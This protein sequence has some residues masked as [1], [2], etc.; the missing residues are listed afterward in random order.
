MA[1]RKDTW[2]KRYGRLRMRGWSLLPHPNPK[3]PNL[4]FIYPPS[5]EHS[6]EAKEARRSYERLRAANAPTVEQGEFKVSKKAV[7]ALQRAAE[8]MGVNVKIT[9]V[10]SIPDLRCKHGNGPDCKKCK[11]MAKAARAGK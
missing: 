5:K 2:L 7:D 9:G 8:T 6:A 11:Q 1:E 10:E 3:L 4:M